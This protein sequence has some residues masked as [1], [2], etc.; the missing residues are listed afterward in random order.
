MECTSFFLFSSLRPEWGG[1]WGLWVVFGSGVGGLEGRGM[2]GGLFTSEGLEG[3]R[4]LLGYWSVGFTFQDNSQTNKDHRKNSR[5]S[6]P[7]G[8]WWHD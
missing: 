1:S 7:T 2:K 4:G 3:W 8:R 6:W 5:Q